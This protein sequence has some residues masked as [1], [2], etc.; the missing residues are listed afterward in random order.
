MEER[1]RSYPLSPISYLFHAKSPPGRIRAGKTPSIN[2]MSQQNPSS[3]SDLE[4]RKITNC[5]PAAGVP[6]SAHVR[7]ICFG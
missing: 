1:N 4:I 3:L 7:P 5:P 2:T 6:Q